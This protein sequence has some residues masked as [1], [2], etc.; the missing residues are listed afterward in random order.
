[1]KETKSKQRETCSGQWALWILTWPEQRECDAGCALP[2]VGGSLLRA[3]VCPHAVRGGA[4]SIW[5]L[6]RLAGWSVV[7]RNQR[8][9]KHIGH[10]WKRMY[11]LVL[12]LR[13][14]RATAGNILMDCR[15]AG[16]TDRRTDGLTD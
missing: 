10:G 6:G 7:A 5:D 4:S 3:T 15:I 14:R 12:V 8:A 11:S 9:G 16:L 2:N 13:Q 1:M